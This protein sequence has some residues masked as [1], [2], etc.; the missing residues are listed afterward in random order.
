MTDYTKTT[1]FT[2]KD[3]LTTGDLNKVV[4]GAEIDAE[5]DALATA[6]ASKVDDGA[7]STLTSL[8]GLTTPLT[9]A[10]GGSG[11]ATLTDGGVLLGSGT[12]AVT[13]M[14][15]L[16]DGEMI[17]GDGTTDPVAES[18]L[19]LLQSIGVDNLVDKNPII[20]GDFNSW[21]EGEAHLVEV[22]NMDN[23]AGHICAYRSGKR[24]LIHIINESSVCVR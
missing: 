2:A 18:G 19:T 22:G 7:N 4:S 12:G 10:Q 23:H 16:A 17:V 13:A 5:F 3:S 15:V 8:T 6:S 20:N 21:Q 11:A 9:V 14:A 24:A 1:N